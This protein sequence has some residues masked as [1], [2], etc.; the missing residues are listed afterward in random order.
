MSD[1]DLHF[2]PLLWLT[3][4]KCNG[5]LIAC[6]CHILCKSSKRGWLNFEHYVLT[7]QHFHC[8]IVSILM[9]SHNGLFPGCFIVGCVDKTFVLGAKFYRLYSQLSE[10]WL[11]LCFFSFGAFLLSC[12]HE[13]SVIYKFLHLDCGVFNQGSIVQPSDW[14]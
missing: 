9:Y 11:Y 14:F 6:L 8:W 2:L 12:C 13:N 4:V 7:H 5:K 10:L 3:C 1:N